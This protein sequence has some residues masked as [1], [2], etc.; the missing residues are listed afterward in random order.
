MWE[1]QF[2]K[3]PATH[4]GR[5][6]IE[7]G[8]ENGLIANLSFSQ[9]LQLFDLSGVAASRLGIYDHLRSPDYIWCQWLGFE[10]DQILAELGGQVHGFIYPS[11][12]HPGARA[13]AI[14]SHVQSVL[15]RVMAT[16]VQQFSEAR[17]FA[18]LLADPCH[19]ARNLL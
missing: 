10:L 5:F 7:A 9:P 8:A 18:E 17:I 6:V 15:A 11:R 2:C 12:R 13:Y 19:I 4:P 3:N 14:S 16:K 1:A